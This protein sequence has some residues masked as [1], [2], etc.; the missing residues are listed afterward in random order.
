MSLGVWEST[1]L[2]AKTATRVK[3]CETAIERHVAQWQDAPM[4]PVRWRDCGEHF[5]QTPPSELQARYVLVLDSLN[6]CFWPTRKEYNDLALALKRVAE[7][8]PSALSPETLQH[9][10]EETLM[11]EWFAESKQGEYSSEPARADSGGDWGA[12]HMSL[13]SE[14]VRLLREVGYNLEKYCGGS[15]EGLVERAEGSALKLVEQVVRLFPGFRD[16]AIYEGHQVFFY[17]RAQIFVADLWGAFKVGANPAQFGSMT[18]NDL[19]QLSMF[20]DYRVPQLLRH[21]GILTYSAELANKV[22]EE[23]Q[24]SSGS[25]EE[26]EI[27]ACT[28]QACKMIRQQIEKI[29]KKKMMDIEVDWLLWQLAEASK[30]TMKPPHHTLTIYY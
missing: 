23:I 9:M 29:W 3:I 15:V 27:R 24:I 30:S 17:K 14:R 10:T 19:D 6:F 8:T 13:V 1:S 16:H 5:V 12:N 2:V 11:N 20:A 4:E 28:I 25:E 26:I 21:W 18:F 7:E 22:D